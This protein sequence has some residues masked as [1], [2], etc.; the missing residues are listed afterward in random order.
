MFILAFR[1]GCTVGIVYCLICAVLYL[2]QSRLIYHPGPAP[3]ITPTDVGL[4]YEDVFVRAADGVRVH[5]WFFPC[6]HAERVVIVCH[7]NAGSIEDR[8]DYAQTFLDMGHACL[9]FDYRGFGKSEGRPGEEG[10]YLDAEAIY[11]HVV[12]ETGFTADQVVVF[13]KSLGSGV[14]VELAMRKDVSR[15][16]VE[17]AMTSVPDVAARMYR[18]FPARLL[19]T[20]RYDSIAKIGG[21]SV[22][23]LVIHSPG[24]EVIPFDHGLQLYEAAREPKTFLE[25]DGSHNETGF[26]RRAEWREIVDRFCRG[27]DTATAGNP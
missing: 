24:D 10:T 12:A 9:L 15:V 11:D 7:G 14:A 19:T 13:G 21:L 17:A 8:L 16:A 2:V 6:E 26:R 20:I 4:T 5:G 1:I 27:S 25:V 23:V 22:P 18:I 3:T